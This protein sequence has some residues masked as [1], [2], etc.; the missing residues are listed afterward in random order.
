MKK[1]E[2]RPC[3]CGSIN[4]VVLTNGEDSNEVICDDCYISTRTFPTLEEAIAAWN[5]RPLE[6]ELLEALKDFKWAAMI[7]PSCQEDVVDKCRCLTCAGV[8]VDAAIAH[9]EGRK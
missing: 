9:T 1:T 5:T 8:R 3:L 2:L 6:D 7:R 4:I